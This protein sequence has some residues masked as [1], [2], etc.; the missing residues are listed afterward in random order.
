[1]FRVIAT[2]L[3][4]ASLFSGVAFAETIEV[5]M[6]NK[7]GEE[8]MVFEPDAVRV[9]PGDTV[10]FVATDKGHN[11]MTVKG[12]APDGTEDFK[13][14]ISKE[15]EVTFDKEGYYGVECQ[16][17]FAMGMV[18]T[19]AVGN[20]AAPDDFLAGRIPPK[21]KERFEAQLQKLAETAPATN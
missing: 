11:A 5:K 15:I 9:A 7:S 16:P 13:G 19:V 14:K 17:H 10:K 4:A 8:K 3:L 6:L 20:G 2:S 1:M 18:M 12:M 21:A